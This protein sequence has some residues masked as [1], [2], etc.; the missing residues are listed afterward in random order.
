MHGLRLVLVEHVARELPSLRRSSHK[1]RTTS[2]T[3]LTDNA[4]SFNG[5]VL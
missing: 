3:T 5:N 4:R 2:M 1:S